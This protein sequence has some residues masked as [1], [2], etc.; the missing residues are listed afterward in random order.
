MI[1]SPYLLFLGDEASSEFAKT[2]QGV[3]RW[4]P[5]LC[6]GQM[7]M[8]GCRADAG[9]PA[10]TVAEGAEKG[11]KTFVIGVANVGGLIP[12]A[13]HG[14]ILEALDNGLDVAA[15][16]H[17][18]LSSID[19]VREAARRAG[20]CLHDVRHPSRSF[21]P[22][23][24]VPRS[25]K[26][27]LA[28]GTD[29]EAGKMF[30]ALAIERE[31]RRRGME[32]DFRATGQTG[33]FIAGDGV[34]VD[35]VVSD[36]VSGAAEWLSPAN[37]DDHWDIVE[38]QGS[39]HH[40]A[41]AGV[42]LGLIHGSQPDALVVCHEAHRKNL[43]GFENYPI[44]SLRECIHLNL[45]AARLTNP[46]A[47]CV[48]LSVNTSALSEAERRDY[49]DQRSSELDLPCVDPVATGVGPIVDRLERI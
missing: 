21:L 13:W 38:G 40:P 6:V 12:D 47:V 25:G 42:T 8:E 7:G 9:L 32:A 44:P 10:M 17:T 37:D 14:P 39:L 35:A 3:A 48:G 33:I 41:Y 30:S 11:A 26:R 16:L 28:V 31:M 2:A 34:A 43:Y 27:L 19:A 20:R 49:L 22:G 5:E 46:A 23:T 45:Q 36:F 1:P 15:G 24:G 29:C 18:R 4:R